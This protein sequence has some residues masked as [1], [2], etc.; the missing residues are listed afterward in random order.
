MPSL[1]VT[2]PSQ[3]RR[4]AEGYLGG[5]IIIKACQLGEENGWS[6]W[7]GDFGELLSIHSTNEAMGTD[8]ATLHSFS[9]PA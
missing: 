6:A 7:A 3:F 8:T 9:T 4:S 1:A 2:G 5:V